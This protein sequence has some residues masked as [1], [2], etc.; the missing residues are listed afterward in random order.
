VTPSRFLRPPARSELTLTEDHILSVL[1]VRRARTRIFGKNLFSDPA[2]D[3]LLVL[4][5][6]K[7]AKR[8]LKLTELTNV[9]DTP[10]STVARWVATLK[11]RGLIVAVVSESGAQQSE[12]GLS[13]VGATRME[14]LAHQWAS[15]FVA[16]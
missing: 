16:I 5:A 8:T 6:A 9:L 13:S 4:Y 2:W 7:L 11:D 3:I 1:M 12:L 15:A 10:S 14:R